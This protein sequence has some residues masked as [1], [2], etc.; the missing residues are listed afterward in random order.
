MSGIAAPLGIFA[1]LGMAA[2]SCCA[3]MPAGPVICY[4][5]R[6]VPEKPPEQP[7][8]CHAIT[9]CAAHRKPGNIHPTI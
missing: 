3:L 5:G 7:G 4:G 8:A 2:S 9:G 6:D 1:A